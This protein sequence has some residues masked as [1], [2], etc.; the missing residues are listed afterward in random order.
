MAN[1]TVRDFRSRHRHASIWEYRFYFMLIFLV[2]L[3]P[4]TAHCFLARCG[5]LKRTEPWNGIIH[6]AWS[7][8]Q[9]YTPM[10]F[11]A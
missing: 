9:A 8:A 1:K 10:I 4:A 11:S 2:G 7:K 5:I 6:C 3:V